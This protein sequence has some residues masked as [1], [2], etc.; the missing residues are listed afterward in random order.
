[1]KKRQGVKK[2]LAGMMAAAIGIAGFLFGGEEVWASGTS[3]D[4]PIEIRV[5]GGKLLLDSPAFIHQGRVMVPF[6][7]ISEAMGAEVRWNQADRSAIVSN[8]KHTTSYTVGHTRAVKDGKVVTL[9][10]PPLLR[11][12]RVY[13]PLRFSAEGLGGKVSWDNKAKEAMIYPL[14]TRKKQKPPCPKSVLKRSH[15]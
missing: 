12:G 9:D 2:L 5:N 11:E 14:L 13:I 6:R 10:A 3:S 8:G 15:F 7:G 4:K 1:M